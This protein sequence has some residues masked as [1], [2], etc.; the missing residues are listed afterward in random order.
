MTR[1]PWVQA[2]PEKPWA[3]PGVQFD[4]TIG[5]RFPNP[6]LVERQKATYSMPETAEEVADVD[7]ITREDADRFLMLF[8]WAL[9]EYMW[10]VVADAAESLGGGPVGVDALQREVAR[11]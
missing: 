9:G 7:R 5:W 10:T 1:A 4:T 8:G 3:K 2:K 6:R 11:A